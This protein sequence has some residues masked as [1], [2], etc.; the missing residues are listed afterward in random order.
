[1]AKKSILIV[2]R[3]N[4]FWFFFILFINDHFK[5]YLLNILVFLQK[6]KPIE[7]LNKQN[8]IISVLNQIL[9]AKN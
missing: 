8:L 4:F 7:Q 3:K 1:M 5:N 9:N 2:K 6:N